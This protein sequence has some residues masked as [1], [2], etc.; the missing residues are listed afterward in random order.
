MLLLDQWIE[1]LKSLKNKDTI[2]LP[3]DFSDQ[4]TG[5]I[6]VVRKENSYE[7][8][9]GYSMSEGWS[10][11][12]SDIS[13]YIQTIADFTS[14]KVSVIM[15]LDELIT[16]LAQSKEILFRGSVIERNHDK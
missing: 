8:S 11:S 6:R 12:P 5:C 1:A 14:E 13:N 4:Y 2:Y 10:V 15:K 7:I 3:Y 9:P 16:H